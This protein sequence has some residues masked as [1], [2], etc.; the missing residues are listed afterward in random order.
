MISIADIV[1][2]K[3]ESSNDDKHI[4]PL[5][6]MKHEDNLLASSPSISADYKPDSILLK[7]E[8]QSGED[9]GMLQVSWASCV[10]LG[11]QNNK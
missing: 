8:S 10:Y 2:P 1:E 6:S 5:L 11:V 3:D 4:F 7:V 9:K